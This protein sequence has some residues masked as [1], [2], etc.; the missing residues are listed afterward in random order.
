MISGASS[1]SFIL[2][3]VLGIVMGGLTDRFGPRIVLTLCGFLLGL[4]FL[5]MYQVQA[6]WQL[7][8]FYGVLV[9]IGM[10]GIWAPLLSLVARWF[11]RRRGLMTGIVIS[12]GGFGALI[13]PPV[14]TRLI[15]VYNWRLSY[16]LL[17]GMVLVVI[18]VAAQFL[19]RDP[20]DVGQLPYGEDEVKERVSELETG[21]FS[22]REAVYTAQFWVVFFMFFCYGMGIFSILVHIVPNAIGLG[23][24]PVS[25][26]N[27]LASISGISIIGN[28]AMGRAIDKIG[29]RQAFI[30]GFIVLSAGLLWVMQAGEMWKL[31]LFALIFGLTHGG[32]A[33]AQAPLVARLFGLKSHGSIFGIAILGFTLGGASGPVVTGYIFDLTGS[34]Q[35]AFLVC[36]VIGIVGLVLA[37]VLKP[38]GRLGVKI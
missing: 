36:A 7:Y 19:R 17:G 5:L 10:S 15:A 27:I 8:L 21:G 28:F 18:V 31:Y 11:T 16:L 4:G 9:G 13:G 35:L 24:S 38:T 25:A 34:Y 14:I 29:P 23:I 30:I 12:G 3:G 26:A 37:A 20:G 22:L 6:Q 32:A 2:M 33:T 1:L